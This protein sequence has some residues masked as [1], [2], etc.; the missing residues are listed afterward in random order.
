MWTTVSY[1]LFGQTADCCDLHKTGR[2]P[3]SPASKTHQQQRKLMYFKDV[4]RKLCF[5]VCCLAVVLWCIQALL[6]SRR[7]ESQLINS[8][9][10]NR[11]RR[12]WWLYG[13]I[14]VKTF[15][16]SDIQ[17]YYN[18]VW[19]NFNHINNLMFHTEKLKDKK[20]SFSGYKCVC[21]LYFTARSFFTPVLP[22]FIYTY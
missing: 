1:A 11:R 6:E 19:D 4:Q 9:F 7:C 22:V 15:R 10:F 5:F 13:L 14:T 17:K 2:L 20:T 12:L 3:L 18:T 8:C 16:Y 21:S